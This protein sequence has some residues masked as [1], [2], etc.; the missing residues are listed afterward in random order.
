MGALEQELGGKKGAVTTLDRLKKKD[1]DW[2]RAILFAGG[3]YGRY[4]I[5][6]A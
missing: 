4:R 3:P 5:A 2:D 6:T 1:P